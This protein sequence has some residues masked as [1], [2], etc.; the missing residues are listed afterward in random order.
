[1]L[2]EIEPESTREWSIERL[3]NS[4]RCLSDEP[5]TILNMTYA[6]KCFANNKVNV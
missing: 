2:T 4:S 5:R 6:N 3:F 1:M